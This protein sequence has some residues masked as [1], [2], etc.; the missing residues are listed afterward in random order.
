M[1]FERFRDPEGG[2]LRMA[3]CCMPTSRS[4]GRRLSLWRHETGTGP[5]WFDDEGRSLRR[6]FL[7]TPLDGARIT[8]GFG[9]RRHPVLG[10]TRMHQGIDFAAPSGTPVSPRRMAWWRRSGWRSGYGRVITPAAMPDDRRPATP[11]SPAF[12]RGLKLGDRVQP[13]R[14]DR[15]GRL[16]RPGDRHR[17]CTTRSPRTA[18]DGP[19]PRPRPRRPALAGAELAAFQASPPGPDTSQIAHLEPMQEV[20]AAE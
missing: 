2:L 3:G 20:A 13:G 5:D 17:T 6:A 11:I 12:A 16:H 14:D 9:M 7:R 4:A 15:P 1:L 10:F 8:S 19:R 18:G